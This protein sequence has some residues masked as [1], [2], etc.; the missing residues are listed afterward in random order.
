[1]HEF[2]V[3]SQVI[4]NIKMQLEGRN[5]VR[6]E[7]VVL[8]VG[9]LTFLS[10]D[11]LEFSFESLSDGTIIE[12]AKLTIRQVPA[13]LRC[14]SCGFVGPAEYQTDL[15]DHWSVPILACPKCR[16]P[17]E[18]TE[19]KDCILQQVRLEVLDE[20]DGEGV[21]GEGVD[22]DGVDGDGVDGDGV[23]GEGVDGE[24]VDGEGV[25]GEG[26][27]GDDVD[28]GMDCGDGDKTPAD[29]GE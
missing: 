5:V 14:V 10:R 7:E 24:G 11:A 8:S 25:D 2:S 21:D 16:G 6:V 12:G 3:M 20:V 28:G 29:G 9:E 22:G 17:V 19:G 26:V 18:I 13:S 1:M 15:A 23:D 27:D 4:E